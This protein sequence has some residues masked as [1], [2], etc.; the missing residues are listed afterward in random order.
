MTDDAVV[1]EWARG[2]PPQG[3]L[4]DAGASV[5][6]EPAG[7]TKP[8]VR[9][10]QKGEFLRKFTCKRILAVE[11]ADCAAITASMRQFGGGVSTAVLR[12]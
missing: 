8:K 4:S 5:A 9:P 10:I 1:Q 7:T 6:A 3:G 11:K 2:Q 12:A